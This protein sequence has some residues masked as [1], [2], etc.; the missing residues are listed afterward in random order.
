MRFL[1]DFLIVWSH[2]LTAGQASRYSAVLGPLICTAHQKEVEGSSV[3]EE[4]FVGATDGIGVCVTWHGVQRVAIRIGYKLETVRHPK[5][6][7]LSIFIRFA[8]ALYFG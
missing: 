2:V 4:R 6:C 3:R 5:A 7:R 8:T 1:N